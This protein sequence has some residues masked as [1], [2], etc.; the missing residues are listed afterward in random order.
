MI[1][2]NDIHSVWERRTCTR[3]E[4]TTL[5][6]SSTY[7]KTAFSELTN[8]QF[9]STRHLATTLKTI[10]LIGGQGLGLAINRMGN[11]IRQ[12]I[13]SCLANFLSLPSAIPP[14]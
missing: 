12:L 2:E 7:H 3:F 14:L 11:G 1:V 10:I 13:D 4:P 8:F 9:A 5:A 6:P